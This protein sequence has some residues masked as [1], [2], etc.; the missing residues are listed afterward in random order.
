MLLV[1][2]LSRTLAGV[3]VLAGKTLAWTTTPALHLC[4]ERRV[5]SIPQ[6]QLPSLRLSSS[7]AGSDIII[8]ASADSL[9]SSCS[10]TV[11]QIPCLS[12]NYGYLIHHDATGHTAAIDTP[13]ARPYQ[14]ELKRRGWKLTHIFNTHHHW[15]HTGGNME[16]K[17]EG[18]TIYGPA[19]E[20]IPGMDV[21]LTGGDEVEFG[22]TKA[23]IMDVG[24]HTKG[25]I[26][27]YFP[28]DAKVFV[29]DSLFALGCGRMF[30]GT[31]S[32]FWTSL[33]GL[34]ELPDETEVYWYAAC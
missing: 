1:A 10:F 21:A 15:D 26:A 33:K 25:H 9:P 5:L 34:R 16:L 6:Q 20:K 23:K 31:A 19:S 7:A 3:S 18:V 2:H 14:D 30:E 8:M 32:Q 17:T 11:A 22:S 24:G 12:D 29:G 27:Y 28:D 4:R 13:D